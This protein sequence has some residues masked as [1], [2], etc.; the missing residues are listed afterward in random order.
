M[1]VMGIRAWGNEGG[2]A[3][4][5]SEGGGVGEKKK[6]TGKDGKAGMVNNV[7][8]RQRFASITPRTRSQ[9]L[10]LCIS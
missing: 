6:K 3:D 5:D 2:E 10:T 9:P 8:R 7:T 4:E 1:E